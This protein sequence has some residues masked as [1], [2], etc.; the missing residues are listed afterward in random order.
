[1]SRDEFNEYIAKSDI[2]DKICFIRL[3]YS[4]EEKPRYITELYL[5]DP[6]SCLPYSKYC[7]LNDW[8]EGEDEVEILGCIDVCDVTVPLFDGGDSSVFL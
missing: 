2:G 1:M 6:K 4:W 5:Y 3:K 8:Y 7:W